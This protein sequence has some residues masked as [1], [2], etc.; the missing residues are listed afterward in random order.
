[1]NEEK[2]K[3]F[4]ESKVKDAQEHVKFSELDEE[5]LGKILEE[6]EMPTVIRD[7]DFQMGKGEIDIRKLSPQNYKQMMFRM[8][9]ILPNVYLRQI[10]NTLVDISRLMMIW[11]NK[12]GITDISKEMEELFERLKKEI[13][14]NKEVN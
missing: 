3:Q 4:Q 9:A 7:K 2:L 10:L 14:K 1:M 11:M 12:A 8:S 5:T 13:E 6:A